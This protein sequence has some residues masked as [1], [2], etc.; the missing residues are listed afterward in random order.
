[1]PSIRKTAQLV[2]E[3]VAAS[4]EQSSGVAQISRAMAQVEQVTHRNAS[5]SEELAS[6][7]EEM[8]AQSETLNQLVSFFRVAGRAEYSPRPASRPPPP[9]HGLE[10]LVKG[11]GAM[12][13]PRSGASSQ[14]V[15]PRAGPV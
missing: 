2:Q 14:H 15:G 8:S 6:T 11:L 4:G 3:V 7:A 13:A 10:S 12:P 9:A 1:V 5:A